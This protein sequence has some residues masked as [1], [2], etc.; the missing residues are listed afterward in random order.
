MIQ[1]SMPLL[2]AH[3]LT[4]VY[5]LGES[6]FGG[7]AHGEVRAVDDVS[8]TIEAAR[9]SGWSA[10]RARQEHAGAADFAAGGADFGQHSL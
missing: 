1:F 2:E 3:N 8:L 5:P 6:L 9:L 4:K 7:R 10:S